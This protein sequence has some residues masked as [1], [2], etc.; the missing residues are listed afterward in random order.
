MDL[1]VRIGVGRTAEVFAWGDA[2]VLKLFNA[3]FPTPAIERE[4]RAAEVV[5][6]LDVPAPA[7]HGRIGIDGRVGLLFERVTGS[8]MLSVLSQ[9]PWRVLHL[10]EQ[11]ADLHLRIH[12]VHA[13]DLAAQ[14]AFVH[15]RLQRAFE[16]PETV[17]ADALEHLRRL[18]DGERLCHG[19]FHPDNVLMTPRGALVLDWMNAVRGHPAGDV[20]R[21]LLLLEHADAPPGAGLALQVLLRTGRKLFA[22]AYWRR[23]A[24][25]SGLRRAD[26]DAWQ[27]P[28]AVARLTEGVPGERG[29]LLELLGATPREEVPP[30]ES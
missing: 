22:W 13:G 17:R 26:V 4:Q 29:R 10:A 18:P 6:G 24:Q 16:A 3:D 25:R 9:Q 12:A 1:G 2:Q 11:L 7:F 27:L 14:R 20:A 15:K 19:D 21:T 28:L 30:S 8:S 5:S 23:Y